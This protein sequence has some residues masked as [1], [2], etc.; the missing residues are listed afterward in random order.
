[1]LHNLCCAVETSFDPFMTCM[2]QVVMMELILK[3]LYTVL[4][5]IC[6]ESHD[7]IYVVLKTVILLS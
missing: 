6:S 4:M 1:M 3:T 7:A 2:L 5:I